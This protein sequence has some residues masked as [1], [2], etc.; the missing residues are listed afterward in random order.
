MA[1][2]VKYPRMY[3]PYDKTMWDSVS[4]KAMKLQKCSSCGMYR[5]P[6]G[7][8]CPKCLSTEATWEKISGDGK[9]LSWCTFHRQYLPAYPAP[10]TIV[11]VELKEGPIMISNVDAAETKSLKLDAPV[12]MI[13]VQHPDGFTLPRFKL[14]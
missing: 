9:I 5:Y 6:P 7:A 1:D 14:K 12:T 2:P 3:S 10:T 4:E 8:C 13:Y 11:A